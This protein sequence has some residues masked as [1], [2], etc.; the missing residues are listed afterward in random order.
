MDAEPSETII[1]VKPFILYVAL[2]MV[3][4]CHINR[5]VTKDQKKKIL[6]FRSDQR[7][8]WKSLDLEIRGLWFE[9]TL[10]E[11]RWRTIT[12]GAALP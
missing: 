8:T 5:K 12:L 4:F 2:V 10:E 6:N 9:W 1:S 3:F 7:E 11:W